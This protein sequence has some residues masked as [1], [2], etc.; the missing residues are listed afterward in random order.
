MQLAE[1]QL[2]VVEAITNC[3]YDLSDSKTKITENISVEHLLEWV[4][5]D[6]ILEER[7]E[8]QFQSFQAYQ[9]SIP[10]T[11]KAIKDTSYERLDHLLFTFATEHKLRMGEWE[12]NI[13]KFI[14]FIK[15]RESIS[16]SLQYPDDLEYEHII[17]SFK[18][19]KTYNNGKRTAKDSRNRP[20][21]VH[22]CS[23]F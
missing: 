6:S 22:K 2:A 18:F 4:A 1:L 23:S 13:T 15:N 16:R 9:D 5:L 21:L 8:Y 19:N 17:T 10:I 12:N 7:K 11:L 20:N 3:E 14:C